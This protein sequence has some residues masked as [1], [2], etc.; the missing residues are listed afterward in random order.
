MPQRRRTGVATEARGS[1]FDELMSRGYSLLRSADVDEALVEFQKAH[2]LA[3]LAH[4]PEVMDVQ[5]AWLRRSI[6]A[7]AKNLRRG[8]KEGAIPSTIDPELAAAM[9]LGGALQ[10]L[11]TALAATPRMPK[12]R[13]SRALSDFIA[14][15]VHARPKIC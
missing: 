7:A 3:R 10:V 5:Q 6:G 1:Q 14:G 11:A 15:A 8:Q 9:T 4:E 12:R 2:S 13:V